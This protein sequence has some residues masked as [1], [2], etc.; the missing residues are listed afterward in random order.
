MIHLC[1]TWETC[2]DQY[3]SYIPSYFLACKRYPQVFVSS[4]VYHTFQPED[5]QGGSGLLDACDS[6]QHWEWHNFSQENL[7]AAA[8]NAV[9]LNLDVDGKVVER[10]KLVLILYR[11][12]QSCEVSKSSHLTRD[13]CFHDKV[14]AGS[15]DYEQ[16]DAVLGVEMNYR[17][18]DDILAILNGTAV[19]CCDTGGRSD[20]NQ[21]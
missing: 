5:V 17:I 21:D 19:H 3:K 11:M 10:G 7:A 9:V 8:S 20:T 14:T 12:H 2:T 15:T 18:D 16:G 13:L 6:L 1:P 4:T